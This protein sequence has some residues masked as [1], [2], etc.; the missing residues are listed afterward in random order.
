MALRQRTI[1]FNQVGETPFELTVAAGTTHIAVE[2]VVVTAPAVNPPHLLVDAFDTNGH[3]IFTGRLRAGSRV[4]LA[5]EVKRIYLKFKSPRRVTATVIMFTGDGSYESTSPLQSAQDVAVINQP[6]VNVTAG[7][8]DIGNRNAPQHID[9]G[10]LKLGYA[11][12]INQQVDDNDVKPF[13]IAFASVGN[14]FRVQGAFTALFFST[15][16]LREFLGSQ[17]IPSIYRRAKINRVY[18]DIYEEVYSTNYREIEA[19]SGTIYLS[20]TVESGNVDRLTSTQIVGMTQIYNVAG[21]SDS[22]DGA[23]I[24]DWL[25]QPRTDEPLGNVIKFSRPPDT[26]QNLPADAT[27]ESMYFRCDMGGASSAS[28]DAGLTSNDRYAFVAHAKSVESNS[29]EPIVRS[30]FDVEHLPVYLGRGDA[31]GVCVRFHCDLLTQV[32]YGARISIEGV[33]SITENSRL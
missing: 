27:L 15:I 8:I 5:Q 13:A 3:T 33:A 18:V 32:N 29:H 10:L 6:D 30:Y 16:W 7:N 24:S 20:S 12:S 23:N 25:G 28:G 9:N 31:I 11:A 26:T 19:N 2:S 21:K 14:Q 22:R 1:E 4:S 17:S